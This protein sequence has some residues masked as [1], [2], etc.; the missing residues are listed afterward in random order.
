MLADEDRPAQQTRTQHRYFTPAFASPEQ[1]RAEP[2]TTASDIYQ[3]GLLITEGLSGQLPTEGETLTDAIRR[4]A[5]D[6]PLRL[7]DITRQSLP[8]GGLMVNPGK[9]SAASS[10]GHSSE[11]RQALRISLPILPP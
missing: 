7:P 6:R 2:V 10:A 5:D 9:A 8:G 11:A 4:S 1:V 3:L